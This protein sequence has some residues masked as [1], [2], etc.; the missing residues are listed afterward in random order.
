[1]AQR[2]SAGPAI[3]SPRSP[4]CSRRSPSPPLTSP[5]TCPPPRPPP[6]PE[7]PTARPR[8]TSGPLA[9]DERLRPDSPGTDADASRSPGVP[10][11]QPTAAPRAAPRADRAVTGRRGAGVEPHTAAAAG[12]CT[13]GFTEGAEGP[14][15]GG[16]APD[17]G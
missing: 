10:P 5:P 9:P 4:P 12:A 14:A 8:D 13:Y 17:V 15:R 1:M 3:A 7:T 11:N 6:S 2:C 16:H